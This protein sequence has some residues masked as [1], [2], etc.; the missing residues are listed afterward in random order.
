MANK[1][2]NKTAL[3]LAGGGLSGAYYEIGAL[4]AINDLLVDRTVNDFDIYIGTSSGALISSFIANGV[5][6]EIMFRVL[7][8]TNKDIRLISRK[9]I[10]KLNHKEYFRSGVRIPAKLINAFSQ[11]LSNIGNTTIIDLMW[12]LSDALPVGFYDTSRIAEFIQH[13]FQELGINDS[14]AK[15]PHEFYVIATDLGTG[16]RAIFGRDFIETSISEAIAA[17]SALPI[18]YKPVT[19]NGNEYIDGGLRGIASLDLAIERGAKLVVCIN[20]LVPLDNNKRNGNQTGE[21]EKKLCE[22]GFTTIANQTIR[23]MTHSGL[24][25]HIKQLKRTCQDVDIIL[26]EPKPNDQKMFTP[27]IMQYSSRLS[28]AQHGFESVT[29]DLAAEYPKY[30]EILTRHSIPITRRLVNEE[31]AEIDRSN[32][33]PSVIRKIIEARQPR[34]G[35]NRKGKAISE[36]TRS[37]A[38]LEMLIEQK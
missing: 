5:S 6:P 27:N 14:F 28:I 35:R 15:I 3:V 20:P 36:L 33:D 30:K 10:F 17:S 21:V 24:H 7:N 12:T 38:T 4:R 1:N 2:N 22:R 37:L 16:N 9:E 34:F 13:T 25:Y 19:I 32:H 8:G 26:I 11:F 29:Y 18:F 23:I 31:L